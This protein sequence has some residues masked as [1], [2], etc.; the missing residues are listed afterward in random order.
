METALLCCRWILRFGSLTEVCHVDKIFSV[1]DKLRKP[2][3]SSFFITWCL[4]TLKTSVKSEF[5]SSI[6]FTWN[7]VI[8]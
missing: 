5:N 8:R 7:L 1:S 3:G 6:T 4:K 2:A